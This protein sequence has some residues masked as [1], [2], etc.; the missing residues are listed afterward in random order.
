MD[1]AL[2]RA[3][4]VLERCRRVLVLAGAGLSAESGVPTFRGAGGLWRRF[5]AEELAT[6][7][8]FARMP[9]TVWAWYRWRL[10][11][12]L[13]ARPNA[14]HRA[15][16]GLARAR[17]RRGFA[18]TVFNQNVDGLLE[19]AW[20]DEELD[21]AGVAALHGSLRHARCRECGRVLPMAEVPL[22]DLPHCACGGLLRPAVVWFG[23]SLDARVLAR[24]EQAGREMEALMAVGTSALVWPAAGLLPLARARGLSVLVVNP[25]PEAAQAG[26]LLLAAGAAH[27]LPQLL[28]G[29]KPCPA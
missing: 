16:A 19:E 9:G 12:V 25:D 23:E 21:P 22:D 20:A 10:E 17:L 14:G 5:R 27:I 11:A 8:A 7:E 18:L 26:D 2:R 3:R 15:L 13:Q 1:E 28:E 6:P 4:A 29:E 24:L